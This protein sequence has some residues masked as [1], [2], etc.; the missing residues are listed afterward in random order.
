V[1]FHLLLLQFEQTHVHNVIKVTILHHTSCYTF[2]ASLVHRQG[3][4]SCTN[5][6]LK[7]SARSSAA[8]N[9]S[10]CNIY[11]ADIIVPTKYTEQY[12]ALRSLHFYMFRH[13]NAIL[14]QY[15]PSL[16]RLIV[17]LITSMN[18]SLLVHCTSHCAT[19]RQVAGYIPDGVSG[20]FH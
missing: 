12:V 5:F 14:R 1:E 3:A 9:S 15:S 8:E 6:C 17:K 20:I 11:V 2:Q 19:S 7:L 13:D 4:Y 16:K 10:L 18:L